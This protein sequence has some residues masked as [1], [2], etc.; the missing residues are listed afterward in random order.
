MKL[1]LLVVTLALV[2]CSTYTPPSPTVT[3]YIG[4]QYDE[5]GQN[6][7]YPYNSPFGVDS[8]SGL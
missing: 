7:A 6:T 8:G 4:G 5:F 3:N 1:V 2:G